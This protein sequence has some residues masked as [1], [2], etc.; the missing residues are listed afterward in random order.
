MI[1]VQTVKFSKLY[2]KSAV[3]SVCWTKNKKS[4]IIL[5]IQWLVWF[6]EFTKDEIDTR[7]ADPNGLIHVIVNVWTDSNNKSH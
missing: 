3:R 1:K 4:G 2:R 5:N 6:N 7:N